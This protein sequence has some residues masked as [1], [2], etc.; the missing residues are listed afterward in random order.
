MQRYWRIDNR[1][2]RR[3]VAIPGSMAICRA[4]AS[5]VAI[6]LCLAARAYGQSP[7]FLNGSDPGD[8]VSTPPAQEMPFGPMG[9][10]AL[11]PDPPG[12]IAGHAV[13]QGAELARSSLAPEEWN[14]AIVGQDWSWQVLPSGLIYRSYLAGVREPRFASVWNH[15]RD[16]G[17]MWDVALGGRAGV[18]RYGDHDPLFPQGFQVDIEGAGFPRLDVEHDLDVLATDFRFGV[19]FTF[20]WGRYQTKLAYYHLSSHLG[21][22]FMLRFP[23]FPRINYSRNALV[24]GHSYYLTE[25]LRLYGEAAWSFDTDGGAEPW[26]FQFGIDYSPADW[27]GAFRGAP[28]IALNAH[29]RE[30]VDFGGNFVVQTGWQWR[31]QTGHLFRLGMQYSTGKSEQYE[32]YPQHEDK[33]GLGVWYDF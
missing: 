32:F 7:A 33:L 22:E 11:L 21:D 13:S 31:G 9:A 29:L 19:P 8:W 5:V 20:G 1:V 3:I 18:L 10:A 4:V 26:E 15:E 23:A 14:G 16:W 6:V 2:R 17:W 30:E 12:G 27:I 28:F 25:D 24:W